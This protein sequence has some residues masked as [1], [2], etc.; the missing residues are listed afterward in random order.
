MYFQTVFYNGPWLGRPLEHVHARTICQSKHPPWDQA[1]GQ[2]RDLC[3]SR[4]EPVSSAWESLSQQPPQK[5]VWGNNLQGSRP[6]PGTSVGLDSSKQTPP[7]QARVSNLHG[8]R[9]EP[10]TSSGLGPASDL[11]RS[12]PQLGTTAGASPS[13]QHQWNQA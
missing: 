2:A 8:S 3:G 11:S 12:R 5:R 9:A 6:E 4:P 7:E 13:K 10:T 1:Q